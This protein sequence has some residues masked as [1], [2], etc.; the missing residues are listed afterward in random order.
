METSIRKINPLFYLRPDFAVEVGWLE[1]VTRPVSEN[2][3]K[4]E[5]MRPSIAALYGPARVKEYE[6]YLHSMTRL[7]PTPLMLYYVGTS[8]TGKVPTA[9]V[10]SR[11]LPAFV[12]YTFF[13]PQTN[14]LFRE[15]LSHAEAGMGL[16]PGC[17]SPLRPNQPGADDCGC[18]THALVHDTGDGHVY[19][20]DLETARKLV[21]NQKGNFADTVAAVLRTNPP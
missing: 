13:C 6:H 9:V 5:R 3:W 8:K 19:V 12:E 16:V 21:G 10:S 11:R 18:A 20:A 4:A 2:D 17:E 1:A 15:M 14:P 7:K